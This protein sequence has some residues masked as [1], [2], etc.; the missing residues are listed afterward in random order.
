MRNALDLRYLGLS[1]TAMAVS[2]HTAIA[3]ARRTGFPILVA[4]LGATVAI[5]GCVAE[6]QPRATVLRE[7]DSGYTSNNGGGQGYLG[8]QLNET[9]TTRV[10]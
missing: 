8:N 1:P 9:I 6:P 4:A 7:L 5:I 10:R 2:S 3:G